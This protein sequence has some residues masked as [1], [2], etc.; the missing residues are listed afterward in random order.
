MCG[1]SKGDDKKDSSD[2]ADGRSSAALAYPPGLSA[3]STPEGLLMALY[4]AQVP[5]LMFHPMFGTFTE[6]F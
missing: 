1:D 2:D 3:E 5:H 4:T 6:Q